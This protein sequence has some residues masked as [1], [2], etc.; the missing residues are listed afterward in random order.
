MLFFYI[1]M[2]IF[3]KKSTIMFVAIFYGQ[4]SKSIKL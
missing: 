3:K 4:I 1:K 2:L